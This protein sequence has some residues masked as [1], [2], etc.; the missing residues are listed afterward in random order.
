MNIYNEKSFKMAYHRALTDFCLCFQIYRLL[1]MVALTFTKQVYSNLLI[2]SLQVV[3]LHS[4]K[5]FIKV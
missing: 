1:M 4:F 2:F 5:R 3:Y